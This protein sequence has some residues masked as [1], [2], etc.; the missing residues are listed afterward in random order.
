VQSLAV[1][2]YPE[3][4]PLSRI[5][6]LGIL[7]AFYWTV[8]LL[9]CSSLSHHRFYVVLNGKLEPAAMYP[10]VEGRDL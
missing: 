9:G 7:S 5:L 4:I 6:R 2:C 10:G 3:W 1:L 8:M